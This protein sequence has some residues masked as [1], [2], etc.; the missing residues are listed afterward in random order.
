[1]KQTERDFRLTRERV[2]RIV[3]QSIS[4]Y[5]SEKAVLFRRAIGIVAA[6]AP[7]IAQEVE[8]ALVREGITRT[9][10]RLESMLATARW[11]EIDPGWKVHNRN[12]VRFV[13]KTSEL[14][15]EERGEIEPGTS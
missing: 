9:P 4:R 10:F 14:D 3:W 6:R 1:M 8:A 15:D 7:T 12:G 2:R 5:A 11:F 13:A